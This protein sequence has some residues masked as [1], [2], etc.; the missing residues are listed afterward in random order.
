MGRYIVCLNV[1][2]SELDEIM[3]KLEVA[4]KTIEECRDA[5]DDIDVTITKANE[6]AG[7]GN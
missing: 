7:S 4:K 3:H 5:L 2:K 1:G 6:E